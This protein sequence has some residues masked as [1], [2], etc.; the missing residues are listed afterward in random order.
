MGWLTPN[1]T[2]TQPLHLRFKEHYQK[3]SGGT[4]QMAQYLRVPATLTEDLGLKLRA[5]TWWLT[6]ICHSQL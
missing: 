6:V 1:G 2:H 5:P 3:R 4:G